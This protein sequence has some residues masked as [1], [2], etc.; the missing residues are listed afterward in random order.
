MTTVV[1]RFQV[2]LFAF[3]LFSKR[4]FWRAK[5]EKKRE[6]EKKEMSSKEC[7]NVCFNNSSF[8]PQRH[9]FTPSLV[10]LQIRA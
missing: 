6:N 9:L 5:K 1:V 7:V 2:I 10:F 8:F 3:A 4:R